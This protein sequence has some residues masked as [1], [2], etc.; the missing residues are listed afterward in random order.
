MQ[1]K[2]NKSKITAS[3]SWS[4]YDSPE[5]AS[6]NEKYLP[7]SGEGDNLASQIV[8]CVNKLIY[9]WYND[10]DVYDNTHGLQGWANDLSSYAN[11]LYKYTPAKE[12][13]EEIYTINSESEY[14]DLL[15]DIYNMLMDERWLDEQ[16]EADAAPDSIYTCKGPFKFVEYQDEDEYDDY[17]DEEDYDDYDDYDEY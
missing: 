3:V 1:I 13:L 4:Y 15:Q 17:E 6:I 12:L 8:T 11:W 5:T 7:D 10:G 9:K 16:A 2:R 14:E